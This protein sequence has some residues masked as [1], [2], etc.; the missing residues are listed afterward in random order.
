MKLTMLG[1]G[2]A[3]VTE[4]YNTCF[5]IDDDGE[6]FLVDGGGGNT[7]LRQLKL[8][9]VD[10]RDVRDIF[11]THKHVD[12][13]MGVMWLVRMICQSMS[14]SKYDG[15]ARIYGH[16]E[17]IELIREMAKMLYS[18]KETAYID[19]RLHLITVEDGE[20]KNIIG[21]DI[22]FFDVKSTKAK[23]FG[24]SMALDG[25]K[26]LTCCGDEPYRDCEEIYARGSEWLLHEVFC[27][28]AEKEE[29]K[30]YQKHHSTAKDACELAETLG[31]KNL[32]LYHTEDKNIQN[33]KSLYTEEGK[34]YF[35]GKLYVPDDLECIEL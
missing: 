18:E 24:F 15:E 11:I 29:F 6:Y 7:I 12:H 16:S 8:A 9:G 14:R 33:R 22:T 21:R 10:W 2:N 30:P 20:S 28:Y 5:I 25:E 3:S 19:K 31:V 17:V 26:R 1:T 32:I 27:L 13:L 35:S 34:I 4:C 23:Q